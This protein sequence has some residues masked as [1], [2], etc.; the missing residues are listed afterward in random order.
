MLSAID[1]GKRAREKNRANA[2]SHLVDFE[3]SVDFML[4]YL[5]I[6]EAW[7][8]CELALHVRYENMLT[9]YKMEADRLLEFLK[10]DG[11][12]P[13]VHTVIDKY[14][15]QHAQHDQKGLHFN[16]GEIG[17]FRQRMTPEQHEVMTV[18]FGPYLD[19]MGY[20]T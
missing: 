14:R 12:N 3:T 16:K 18:K 13:L 9:D 2:F 20:S 19:R 6:W 11:Q 1:N 15:P 4:D 8:D 5:R 10:I 7:M 17:R